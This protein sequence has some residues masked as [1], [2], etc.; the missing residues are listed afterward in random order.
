MVDTIAAPTAAPVEAVTPIKPS[1]ALR[2]G[3]VL[4]PV[5]GF[6]TCFGPEGS[7][8]ACAIGAMAAGFGSADRGLMP[9]TTVTRRL[10][11]FGRSFAEANRIVDDV[12]HINDAFAHRGPSIRERFRAW[13]TGAPRPT[14]TREVAAYL[15]GLGL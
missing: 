8:Q 2:L 3:R 9:Y 4:Y 10:M 1:E 11:D 6:V 5:E 12:W 14:A 13:R 7:H 15:E